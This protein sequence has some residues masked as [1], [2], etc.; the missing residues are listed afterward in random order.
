MG[1]GKRRSVEGEGAKEVDMGW[2]EVGCLYLNGGDLL[3][4]KWLLHLSPVLHIHF[5]QGICSLKRFSL[6]PTAE[7][8]EE[9]WTQPDVQGTEVS[10]SKPLYVLIQDTISGYQRR[11]RVYII[12]FR[13]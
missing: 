7:S 10:G 9:V 13:R 8:T 3:N 12:L 6:P 5:L 11:R 1:E 4:L 2:G